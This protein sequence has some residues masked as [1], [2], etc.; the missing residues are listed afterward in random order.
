[1]MSHKE[2]HEMD[3]TLGSVLVVTD[4]P[5]FSGQLSELILRAGVQTVAFT[6]TAQALERTR[7]A[8]PA[9]ILLHIP[10]AHLPAGVACYTQLQ[11]DAL[12]AAIPMLMYTPAAVLLERAVGAADQL[13]D[14]ERPAGSDVLI[15]Q[16]VRRILLARQPIEPATTEQAMPHG[17]EDL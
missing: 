5:A 11:S 12:T 9:L 14:T 15:A 6:R 2:V 17:R 13:A 3:D 7:H 16:L 8:H 10:N 4:E 1:M